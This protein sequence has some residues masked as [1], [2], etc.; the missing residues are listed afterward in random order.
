[1]SIQLQGSKYP[2]Q[3]LGYSPD[4]ISPVQVAVVP[5]SKAQ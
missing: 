3:E 1:M 2:T 5:L 4:P